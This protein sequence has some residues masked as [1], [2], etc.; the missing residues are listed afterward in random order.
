MV[1]WGPPKNRAALQGAGPAV[2]TPLRLSTV[3][4]PSV[5]VDAITILSY[6]PAGDTRHRAAKAGGQRDH[7][8]EQGYL[9]GIRDRWFTPWLPWKHSAL[10][11]KR[12]TGE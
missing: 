9:R 2:A 3:F 8:R 4:A 10:E 1:T 5:G 6:S 12:K 11:E 7:P